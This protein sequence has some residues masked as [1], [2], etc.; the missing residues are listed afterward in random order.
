MSKFEIDLKSIR[1]LADLIKETGINEIEVSEGEQKI[2]CVRYQEPAAVV[3]VAPAPVAAAP[4]A[5]A[6]AAAQAAA[7]A[8]VIAGTPVTSPM[9]GTVYMSPE[10]GAAPFVKVGDKVKQG[11]TLCIIEAMKVMNPIKAAKAGTV[12]SISVTDTQPVEYGET[13]MVID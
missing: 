12:V 8:P 11:D 9:V 3:S 4:V 13:L 10:P 7:A 5:A 2:R 6:P 1:A